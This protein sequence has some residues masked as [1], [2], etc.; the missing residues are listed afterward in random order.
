[1]DIS[2]PRELYNRIF[3]IYLPFKKIYLK[4]GVIL[5]GDNDGTVCLWDIRMANGSKSPITSFQAT[6]KGKVNTISACLGKPLVSVS[7]KEKIVQIWDRRKLPL[8]SRKEVQK[9]TSEPFAE[10]KMATLVGL[11]HGKGIS[12]EKKEQYQRNW[13]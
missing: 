5:T 2:L 12:D 10:I 11:A 7:T 13:L 8:G 4:A 9:R 6:S 3:T 1:M